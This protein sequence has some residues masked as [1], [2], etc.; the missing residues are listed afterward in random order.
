VI[1]NGFFFCE[2]SMC[3]ERRVEQIFETVNCTS[4]CQ[5]DLIRP[6][7]LCLS[8]RHLHEQ[9]AKLAKIDNC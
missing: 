9:S 6:K 8:F 4:T 7:N 5:G 1:K 3:G 2:T